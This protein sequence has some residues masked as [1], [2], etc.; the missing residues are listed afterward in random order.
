[1][2]KVLLIIMSF[3]LMLSLVGIN[4][5]E[6]S[7]K[8]TY[9]QRLLSAYEEVIDYADTLRV[10][11]EFT[12]NS[13]KLNY[14]SFRGSLNEY[15]E[16]LKESLDLITLEQS[17]LPNKTVVLSSGSSS[18]SSGSDNWY[19]N[20]GL[21]L[22]QKGDYTS[23]NVVASVNKGD[24][25]FESEG[26]GGLTGHIAVVEGVYYSTEHNQ[27]FIRVIE[28]IADGVVRSVLDCQ[29]LIDRGGHVYRVTGATTSDA[30]DVIDFMIAQLG[31]DFWVD[32]AYKNCYTW[33]AD[34][35]CSQLAYCAYKST[36]F[37]IEYYYYNSLGIKVWGEFGITPRDI[38]DDNDTHEQ[39]VTWMPSC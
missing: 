4:S 2:K 16:A 12:Y 39:S 6:A 30:D 5:V 21:T 15:V 11:Y 28:A 24:I 14:I 31:K 9:D 19:Y 10:D 38:R 33:Q 32:L 37:N 17:E 26:S 3:T 8:E 36:G 35:Y 29:R 34:W 13:F 23:C 1:M 7:N 22:P 27:Y 18:S 25:I 20:T